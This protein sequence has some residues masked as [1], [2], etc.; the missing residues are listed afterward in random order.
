M[1]LPRMVNLDSRD[2]D[3][4]NGFATKGKKPKM[5]SK[6]N[7]V[8]YWIIFVPLTAKNCTSSQLVCISEDE[9]TDHDPVFFLTEGR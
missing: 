3:L 7:H 5:N 9:G 4:Y 6:R 1:S 8:D 2:G